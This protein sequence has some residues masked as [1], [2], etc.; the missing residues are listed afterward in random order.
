MAAITGSR[1]AGR[2][3]RSRLRSDSGAE[4]IELAFTLPLL[5]L[6]L[7]GIMDFG[8]L[9]QRYEAVTNAAREGARIGVLPGYQDADIADRVNRYLL[10][11][12]FQPPSAGAPVT[13]PVITRTTV[14]PGGG[15][16]PFTVVQVAVSY[17]YRFM[18]LSPIALFFGGS[19]GN[20]TL[21]AVSAMRT[22][23]A[24]GG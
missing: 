15:G 13:T 19:F 18:F 6:V 24:A 3:H 4:L 21:G 9:F 5:L 17:P 8:F 2:F 23:V 10:A 16:P 20:I 22:E 1:P 14:T 7:V 12:G 11:A